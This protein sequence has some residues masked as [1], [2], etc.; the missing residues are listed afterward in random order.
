MIGSD[1]ELL[2]LQSTTGRCR[3]IDSSP[4]NEQL[5]PLPDHFVYICADCVLC[6][7]SFSRTENEAADATGPDEASLMS[8]ASGS[9]QNYEG[10]AVMLPN[11]VPL[12]LGHWVRRT[13]T[14]VHTSDRVISRPSNRGSDEL[15]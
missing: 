9:E 3:R 12:H 4:I 7:I 10:G 15:R 1:A 13:L 8:E 14:T 6:A 5:T 2:I 11:G